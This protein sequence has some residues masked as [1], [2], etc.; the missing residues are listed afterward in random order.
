[1]LALGV[2]IGGG[3]FL[4]AALLLFH[5]PRG[6][7]LSVA[8]GV[9]MAVFAVVEASVADLD[10]WLRAVGPGPAVDKGLPSTVP[11]GVASMLGIPLPLWQQPLYLALGL[12]IATLALLLWRHEVRGAVR[13]PVEAHV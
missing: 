13:P 8:V 3:A 5:E 12:V 10:V 9:A 1:M 6:L 11:G 4:A 2:A 7:P